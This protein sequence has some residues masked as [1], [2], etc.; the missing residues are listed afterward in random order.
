MEKNWHA[1]YVKSRCEK[2]VYQELCKRNIQAYLPLHKV[3]RQWSDRKKMVEVPIINSY[4]FV[5]VDSSDYYDVLGISGVVK[6]ICFSGK[7]VSVPEKQIKS[8]QDVLSIATEVEVIESTPSIGD[9]INLTSGPFKGFF[10]KVIDGKRFKF[11]IQLEQIGYN[12]FVTV[13]ISYIGKA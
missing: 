3:M 13:P 6:Y 8:L 2:K 12:V 11:V 9:I 5:H 4:L 7:A 1:I 10:G